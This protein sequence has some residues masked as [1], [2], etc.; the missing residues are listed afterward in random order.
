[1]P[2]TGSSERS[3][4]A[5]AVIPAALLSSSRVRLRQWT[6]AD[7]EPFAAL[8]ADPV[9]MEH[10]P[11]TLNRAGSD[12]MVNR[13]SASIAERGWGFWAADALPADGAAPQFIGFIGLN[14]PQ[15]KAL[16]F[17]PCVEIGW[18]LARPFWGQGLASEGARLAL[19]VGFDLLNLQ[20][21]VAMTQLRNM[22][23][24]AVME[25]LGMREAV[26]EEFEH[27]D[28]PVGSHA[29]AMCLYRLAKQRPSQAS[30]A[31][32]AEPSE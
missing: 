2:A 31:P 13:F 24:R 16:P 3:N 27:P 22:R 12:E 10:F 4:A 26:G 15:Q 17:Q 23:S 21:I 11:S 9:V 14:I 8:N 18:R 1:M 19:G 6:D 29:R 20:E 7:R 30:V 28:V 25:R 32:A 5:C